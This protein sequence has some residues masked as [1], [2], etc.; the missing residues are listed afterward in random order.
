[1]ADLVK[2]SEVTEEPKERPSNPIRQGI[3]GMLDT[4]PAIPTLAGLAGAGIEGGA[5]TLF[6]DKSFGDNFT[7]SAKTGFD[8]GLLDIGIKGFDAVNSIVG[9]KNPESTEDIAARLLGS[10]FVPVPGGFLGGA[11]AKGLSGLAGRAATLVSPAV[12][13]GPKGNRLNKDFAKRAATQ[14]G[15][16]T[17]LDQGLRAVIDKPELPLLF[18]ESALAGGPE[19]VTPE[20][21][22]E[23][24]VLSEPDP[25]ATRKTMERPLFEGGEAGFP[26]PLSGD[27]VLVSEVLEDPDTLPDLIPASEVTDAPIE[28]IS[29]ESV[30]DDPTTPEKLLEKEAQAAE[31]ADTS[32]IVRNIAIFAGTAAT[33]LLGSKINSSIIASKVKTVSGLEPSEQASGLSDAIAT[34]KEAATDANLPPIARIKSTKKATDKVLGNA[35]TRFFG[36][37]FDRTAHTEQQLKSVGEPQANIDQITAQDIVDPIGV[38]EQFLKDGKFGQGSAQ[39]I[40]SLRSIRREYDSFN[41]EQQ[42]EFIDGVAFIQEDIARTRGTAFDALKKDT[43]GQLAEL[44]EAFNTGSLQDIEIILREQADL[45]ASIRGTVENPITSRVKPGLFNIVQQK[46]FVRGI[47]TGKTITVR[48]PIGDGRLLQGIRNFKAN[49][50]YVRMMKDLAKVNESVLNESVRRGVGDSVWA[51]AVKKQFSRDGVSLYLPGKENSS[52]A[53]W[54]K[55]LAT[56]LGFHSTHGKNLNGVA[57]WHLKGLV[58]GEGIKSPLDPFQATANY[59]LQVIQH[60]TTSAK[61]WNTLTRI[62]GLHFNPDGSVRIIDPHVS[63]TSKATKY[64]GSAD[65]NDPGNSGGNLKVLF[66]DDK[67]IAQRFGTKESATLTPQ[68]LAQLDDV[69]WVQRGSKYHGFLVQDKQF[70]KGLEYDAA[71]HNRLLEFG[72]F[73]KN[74]MTRFTTGILSPFGLTSFIYNNQIS[75]FNAILRASSEE[76]ATLATTSKEAFNVW[77]DSYKGAYEVFTTQIAEDATALLTLAMTKNGRMYADNPRIMR[78]INVALKRKIKNSLVAPI[79]RE[80]GNSASGLGASEYQGN[81]TSILEESVPYIS[82]TYGANV[83]PQFWRTWS[84]LNTAMHEGTALGIAM[85]KSH[86]AALDNPTASTSALSRQAKRD[87]NDLVGDVRIRGSSDAA[88]AFHAITPFSGAMMQ[89]WSTMGRAMKKAG[90]QKTMG[91]VTAAIGVP[92]MLEVTYNNSIDGEETYRDKHGKEWNYRDYFWNGFTTDQRNNN[93]I[94]MKPGK[95]PW[96]ALLIPITPELSLFRSIVIDSMEVLYGLSQSGLDTGNHMLAGLV[97]TF[98]IPLNPFISAIGSSLGLDLRAGIIPDDTEGKGFS[99]FNGRQLNTGGRL[100]SGLATPKFE[101]GELDRMIVNIA[102]DIFGAAASTGIG[103]YEGFNAGNE[104]TSLDTRL[105]F[106]FDEVGRNIKRQA[107]LPGSLFGSVLRPS[108]DRDVARDLVSKQD[109]LQKMGTD[110]KTL[111][112]GGNIVKGLPSRGEPTTQSKDPVQLIIGSIAPEA[113]AAISVFKDP[114][115]ILRHQINT[116]GAK[117]IDRFEG[118]QL[119]VKGREDIIDALNLRI[120]AY[121]AQQ[122]SILK[123]FEE[124]VVQTV[125]EN[126]GRDIKGFEFNNYQLNR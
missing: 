12:R 47:D 86:Q 97:R 107:R 34:V 99:F 4:F 65:L 61:Q 77:K 95:P 9:V 18:S 79:R 52:V 8:S 43:N 89:A 81:I 1:M 67:V 10:L 44:D 111:Q 113:L 11:A 28:M 56:N 58:E 50:Q 88:K 5:K 92:T 39:A 64:V 125:A 40:R 29:A 26:A 98:D 83:L 25:S 24:M 55:R 69:I 78:Q 70:K 27:Q 103:F 96:E 80:T 38:T 110:F 105:E 91:A 123:T 23:A 120:G 106:A 118:K 75:T 84:H 33:L 62:V 104:A 114:I 121:Q 102:Q 35:G 72:N 90:W 36:N 124:L 48:D 32:N 54:Y 19:F 7:E 15:V 49:P 37:A 59:A 22:P 41:A 42:Q 68:Q 57:N 100:G 6:N 60:T 66:H 73:W 108:P 31:D 112:T 122:L 17:G 3:A 53:A 16:G 82:K 63:D 30:T 116:L 14:I 126:T 94:I 87:A 119:T 20:T 76:G 117:T 51:A 71:L 115:R 46:V 109:A 85:R 2:A 101:G 45:I 13:L 21:V 74:T 93:H